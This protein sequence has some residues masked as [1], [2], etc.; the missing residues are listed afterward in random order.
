MKDN[1]KKDVQ[2]KK[3]FPNVFS[4]L[5]SFSVIAAILTWIVPAGS[6]ERIVEDGIT[7]VVPGTFSFIE[8]N[9]QDLW[10]IFQALVTAFKNQA[11]L[12]FMIFFVGAAVSMLETTKAIDAFFAKIADLAKGKEEIAVFCIML[13]LSVGG[14]T[15][16]FGNVT[17]VLIPIGIII[18]QAMGFDKTL[19]FL[20]VFL[21]SFS[22]FN[23]GWVN[24]STVGVAQTIAELP[25]FS[26]L[27]VRVL[28]HV[29]NFTISYLFVYAYLRQIRSN[30]QKSLNYKPGLAKELYMGNS[31]NGEVKDVEVTS[32]Q[33]ISMLCMIVGII[34]V[35][36][37]ALKFGWGTDQIAATFFGVAFVMGLTNY[38]DLNLMMDQFT[39]GCSKTVTAAF[40][41]GFANAIPVIMK[42]GGILDTIVYYLSEPIG[43]FGDVVGTVI[44]L[45]SNIIIN[46]FITSGSG[47]AS[48]VMPIMIPICDLTGIT[49]QVA[50]QCFQFGDGLSNC[51]YPTVASL[52]GGLAFADVSYGKYIKK[53][54]PLF[55]LQISLAAVA[56]VIL[57]SIGWTGI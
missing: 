3:W 35:I 44:M 36:I 7:K 22:G 37:G 29:V 31:E 14:A 51:I 46:F 42:A 32:S 49:R 27:G 56:V 40:V 15:G 1:E 57:Q 16:V 18:S 53:V 47:Q 5:F 2:K 41:V 25:M 26:G 12:V 20:M 19:G 54:L 28:F 55:I 11:S 38:K 52:M 48:A 4:L 50:V 43:Y 39:K 6:F 8:K 21:G 30:P 10:D 34:I 13:F 23:T 24:P 17:L 33:M 45:F 9:P